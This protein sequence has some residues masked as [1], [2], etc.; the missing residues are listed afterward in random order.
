MTHPPSRRY[1]RA[2]IQTVRK[3][4]ARREPEEVGSPPASRAASR[5]KIQYKIL[6]NR[7]FG[8]AEKV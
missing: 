8:K 5:E 2:Y 4:A 6:Y 7:L 1:F 3:D